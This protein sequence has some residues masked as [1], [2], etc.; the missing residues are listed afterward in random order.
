MA[1]YANLA[2]ENGSGLHFVDLLK[3]ED[4]ARMELIHGQPYMMAPPLRIHQKIAFEPGR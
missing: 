3:T 1:E 2:E 4:S